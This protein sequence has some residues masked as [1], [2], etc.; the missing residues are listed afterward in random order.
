MQ[1]FREYIAPFLILLIFVISL[2]IMIARS[3]ITSDM[4]IPAP[5]S[6]IFNSNQLNFSYFQYLNTL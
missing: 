5:I 6:L 4:L 3:F 2:V 1:F